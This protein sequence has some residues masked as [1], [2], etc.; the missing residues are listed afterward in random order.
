MK[1]FTETIV[2]T[3]GLIFGLWVIYLIFTYNYP[4]AGLWLLRE[5]LVRFANA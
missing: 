1:P 5:V 2:N 3:F 4:E